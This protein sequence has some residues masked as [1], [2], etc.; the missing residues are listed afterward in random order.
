MG[1]EGNLELEH[2]SSIPHLWAAAWHVVT[3]NFCAS[4]FSSVI[5]KEYL[6]VSYGI[7]QLVKCFVQDYSEAFQTELAI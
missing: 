5:W 2:L 4:V 1:K 6:S 3:Y 7:V